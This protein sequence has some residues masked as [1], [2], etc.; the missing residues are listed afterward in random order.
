MFFFKV[1]T[2]CIDI[3]SVNSAS[4]YPACLVVQINTKFLRMKLDKQAKEEET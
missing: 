1:G 4:E 3:I 2:G